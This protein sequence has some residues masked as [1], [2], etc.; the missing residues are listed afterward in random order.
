M[1]VLISAD[2][3]YDIPD[4]MA[5]GHA[6]GPVGMRLHK[7]FPKLVIAGAPSPVA[8]TVWWAD[9]LDGRPK[10]VV[11]APLP[12]VAA[13]RMHMV[14]FIYIYNRLPVNT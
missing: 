12:L 4:Y 14:A 3:I 2:R 10:T 1:S 6:V 11:P 5:E 13:N 8:F 9:G 7:N